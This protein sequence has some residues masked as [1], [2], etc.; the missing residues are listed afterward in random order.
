[1]MLQGLVGDLNQSTRASM[2]LWPA[3]ERGWGSVLVSTWSTGFPLP[4]SFLSG[5]AEY[6]PRRFFARRMIEEGEADVWLHVGSPTDD[7]PVGVEL[8]VVAPVSAPVDG[9]AVTIVVA[10]PGVEHDTVLF[11]GLAGTFLARAAEASG[12]LQSASGILNQ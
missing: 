10:E 8:V 3:S 1:E 7:I 4:V 6:D 11:S 9:A 5:D 12:Q 2:L